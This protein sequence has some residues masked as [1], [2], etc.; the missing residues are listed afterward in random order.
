VLQLETFKDCNVCTCLLTHLYILRLCHYLIIFM[1]FHAFSITCLQFLDLPPLHLDCQF[2][3]IVTCYFHITLKDFSSWVCVLLSSN[4]FVPY[5]NQITEFVS[6]HLL[7]N[8]FVVSHFPYSKELAASNF[9]SFFVNLVGTYIDE[10]ID[11]NFL[12][13]LNKFVVHYFFS[14]HFS[15]G[16]Q[17]W[18]YLDEIVS[19][20]FT[21]DDL[22][23]L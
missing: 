20:P 8:D 16:N 13:L 19:C 22:P 3:S 21:L 15:F 6:F 9:P 4:R 17:F 14:W 1:N 23:C 2:S 7:V 10:I 12:I 18:P 11:C 5:L